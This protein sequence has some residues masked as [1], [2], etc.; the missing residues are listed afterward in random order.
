M[1]FKLM[2]GLFMLLNFGFALQPTYYKITSK[3]KTLITLNSDGNA[4]I[5]LLNEN[6]NFE[7]NKAPYKIN[8][9]NLTINFPKILHQNFTID[10]NKI[11]AKDDNKF[12]FKLA[13]ENYY[14]NYLG[15]YKGING[16]AI[17]QQS[18]NDS[19]SFEFYPKFGKCE[20]SENIKLKDG[21][22][23]GQNLVVNNLN[24]STI[25]II[26]KKCDW[27]SGKYTGDK[28]HQYTITRHSLGLI[29]KDVKVSKLLSHIPKE[30]ILKNSNTI[31]ILS[32][33]GK[34]LFKFESSK[35]N[36]KTIEILNDMYETPN[37]VNLKSS[38][39][40]LNGLNFTQTKDGNFT[41]LKS[42]F[43]NLYMYFNSN[44][45]A[46]NPKIAKPKKAVLEW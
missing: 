5:S 28:D 39:Q 24:S 25:F 3:D 10:E 15:K 20:I 26:S 23:L 12:S 30:Q 13:D 6:G 1:I 36:I 41:I 27:I 22:I 37:G 45:V 31:T 29:H 35:D 4:Y 38:Y 17:L 44:E 7:Q 9:K 21:L 34:K 46:K 18:G 32:P 8:G 42:D 33:S 19:L 14:K 11:T 40:E 16:T 2:L 43:L